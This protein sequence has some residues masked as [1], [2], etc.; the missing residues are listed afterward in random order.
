VAMDPEERLPGFRKR[1]GDMLP[2]RV[3]EAVERGFDP[4]IGGFFSPGGTETGFAGMRGLDAS[5]TG[6]A[7]PD[8]P[9]E[10]RRSTDE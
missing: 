4:V 6:G 10:E 2:D 7:D 5:A 3:G 8:M 1:P 9:A